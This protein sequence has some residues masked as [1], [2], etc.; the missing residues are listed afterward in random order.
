MLGSSRFALPVLLLGLLSAMTAAPST[1]QAQTTATLAGVVED[2]TGGRLPGVAVSLTEGA[3]NVVRTAQTDAAGRFVIPGLPAGEY[4]IRAT[5]PGFAAYTRSG[6]RLTVA[7]QSTV[8]VTMQP[9]GTEQVTVQADA[10]SLNF[11]SA[12][13]SFLVDRRAIDWLPVNGRN[14]TDLAGLQPGVSVFPHRDNGSVVAHGLAMSVNGQDPRANVY[15]LDGT[16]LNDFTNGPAGSAAGTALGT[17]TV[18]E[19]RVETN[20]YSAEFGRN[21]GGQINV[22]T[23]SGAN[24]VDGSFYEF[25]RNDAL[26]ARNYF[27]A[28]EQPDFHRNQFGGTVGGPI[29]RD[30]AFFFLGYEALVERLGKTVSTVVPDDNARNGLLPGGQVPVSPEVAPYLA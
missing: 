26:D 16:L 4:N 5:L 3:T 28:A 2:A 8:V 7:Q 6:L 12:E 22:L 14:F 13:L 30:R 19:F 25:H 23:K 17:E 10:P 21:S 20:A 9:A 18:R 27:D 11:R 24:S 29:A 15:L 1:A